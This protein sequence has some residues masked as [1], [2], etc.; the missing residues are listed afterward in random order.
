MTPLLRHPLQ[1]Q[2]LVVG[3]QRR[4]RT[5]MMQHRRLHQCLSLKPTLM[6][7][8]VKCAVRSAALGHAGAVEQAGQE[9]GMILPQ[10]EHWS[11]QPLHPIAA[12]PR[13]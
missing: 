6:P 1:V 12:W 8:Y 13:C 9:C 3:R 7:R 4:A 10:L 11:L 2:V 5:R